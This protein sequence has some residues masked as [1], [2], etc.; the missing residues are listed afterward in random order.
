MENK[1]DT[2]TLKMLFRSLGLRSTGA[3]IAVYRT[4]AESDRPMTH[5]E[6]SAHLADAGFDHTTIFRNLTDLTQA[7]LLSRW[8]IGDRVWRFELRG[9]GKDPNQE[10]HP[11]FV[12]TDCGNVSYLPEDTVV[13]KPT[14][15]APEALKGGEVAIQVRGV[16]ND[17]SGL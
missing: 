14:K 8:D 17:C 5:A 10:Q 3:R 2:Q 4:L 12:C 16:C 6:V 13:V 9:R 15:G 1:T 11:H 7:N